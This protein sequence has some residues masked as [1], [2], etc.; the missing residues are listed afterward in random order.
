MAGRVEL[1]NNAD[2][3]IMRIRDEV[4]DLSLCVVVAFRSHAR[5]FGKHLALDAKSLIVGK[6]PVQHVHLHGL[7]AVKSAL[8]YVN[9]DEVAADIDQQ[10]TPRKTRLILDRDGGCG[11]SARS[12]R[13]QLQKS[14]QTVKHT[15]GCGS[16]KLRA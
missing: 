16:R 15:K 10:A 11:K 12:D 14:L 1:W 4:A 5:Q 8:E 7:H 13:D 3:A 6:V 9:R 2:A